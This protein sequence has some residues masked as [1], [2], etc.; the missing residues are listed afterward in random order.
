[1]MWPCLV[2][3]LLNT[4][5]SKLSAPIGWSDSLGDTV[6]SLGYEIPGL[7]N[8]SDQNFVI[9]HPQRFWIPKSNKECPP[10]I[11]LPQSFW[12]TW[13]QAESLLM[14]HSGKSWVKNLACQFLHH[15]WRLFCYRHMRKINLPHLDYHYKQAVLSHEVDWS[16]MLWMM[17]VGSAVSGKVTLLVH[18]FLP[19]QRWKRLV[20]VFIFAHWV[21][22]TQWENWSISLFI[23]ALARVQFYGSG[24]IAHVLPWTQARKDPRLG[25]QLRQWLKAEWCPLWKYLQSHDHEMHTGRYITIIITAT[26]TIIIISIISNIYVYDFLYWTKLV[27]RKNPK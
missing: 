27:K 4:I 3:I 5:I 2:L 16:V 15:F 11:E 12:G 23:L 17:I 18:G 20:R 14:T 8:R 10:P 13:V 26:I 1:M 7:I 22:I 25:P 24:G 21:M 6:L 9:C 19:S